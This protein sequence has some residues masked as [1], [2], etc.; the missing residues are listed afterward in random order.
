MP[1]SES[2]D[3]KLHEELGK[4]L[5]ALLTSL[6]GSAALVEIERVLYLASRFLPRLARLSQPALKNLAENL[7]KQGTL[8]FCEG[9]WFVPKASDEQIRKLLAS[10]AYSGLADCIARAIP[11]I[12]NR[13]L[14]DLN[15]LKRDIRNAFFAWDTKLLNASLVSMRDYFPDEYNDGEGFDFLLK[16]QD[17]DSL[18]DLPETLLAV[19]SWQLLPI[20]IRE[21]YDIRK[22]E[23]KLLAVSDSLPLAAIYP[24]IDYEILRGNWNTAATLIK[25]NTNNNARMLRQAWL[26][27]MFGKDERAVNLFLDSLYEV[28]QL[29]GVHDFYFQTVGGLF[30]LF[31]LLRTGTPSALHTAESNAELGIKI[32]TWGPIYELLHKLIQSR[33]TQELCEKLP[34]PKKLD[35]LQD[36]FWILGQYWLNSE[37]TADEQRRL[38]AIAGKAKQSDYQWLFRECEELLLRTLPPGKGIAQ[39]YHEDPVGKLPFLLDCVQI[40]NSW[41]NRLSKFDPFLAGLP[42]Q[43]IRRL[44]WLVSTDETN[45]DLLTVRPMEQHS[46]RS[47][48]WSKG[49]KFTAFRNQNYCRIEQDLDSFMS[50]YQLSPQDKFACTI[51]REA[52]T[53]IEEDPTQQISAWASVFLA[54]AGHPRMLLDGTV[55]RKLHCIT[56]TPYIRLF[57]HENYYEFQLCPQ[58]T[59]NELM[60]LRL[61]HGDVISVFLFDNEFLQLR[62][63]IG[64]ELRLPT[65]AQNEM[66]E[67]LS[68][69]SKR[70]QILSDYPLESLGLDY[71]TADPRPEFRLIPEN[72]GL[73]IELFIKPFGISNGFYKPG[74]G[75]VEMI[76][77]QEVTRH[78]LCRNFASEIAKAEEAIHDCPALLK[79]EAL[80]DWNWSL[81]N[82][83]DCYEFTLQLREILSRCVVHWPE[84]NRFSSTR[85]IGLGNLSLRIQNYKDWFS[86]DGTIQIDENKTVSLRELLHKSNEEKGRFIVLEDGQ[87]VALSEGF[88]HRLDEL[89]RIAEYKNEAFRVHHFLQPVL[90]SLISDIGSCE[91]SQ[92]W[93]EYI[94]KMEQAM[95]LEPEIPESLH[96]TL[97]KYQQE[98]FVWLFRLDALG[99][100]ACLADDMGLGKTIQ[101][102]TL[103]LSKTSEGPSLIIAPTSVCANWQHEFQKFAPSL[104]VVTLGNGDR[105]ETL[106]SLG[107]N[108][109]LISSYGLLQSE[110]EQ[111]GNINWRIAVLD[112]A[113]AI[114]N[115]HAKRSQAAMNIKAKFRLVTTGTPVENNLNELWAVFRFINP[116][117]LGPREL[118][119]RRFGIPIEREDNREAM[120]RLNNLIKPFLLRRRKDQVLK[121]LPPKT[122]IDFTVELSKLEREFYDSLRQ[123][124]LADLEHR[125]DPTGRLRIRVLAGITKLRLATCHPRLAAP[126]STLPGAKLEAFLELLTEILDGGHKTLVF[127][128]FVKFLSIVR[129]SL[130]ERGI[131]YQYLDG[132]L[133][134]KERTAAVKNFQGGNCPVFLISLKAGGLGLNLTQA[135][136]VIHLDSWWNPAVENQA[137]DRAHRL[138]QNKPVTIYHLLTKNTIEDKIQNLHQWKRDLADQIL[139]GNDKLTSFS[140]QDLIK[141]LADEQ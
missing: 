100:G 4:Q 1:V 68:R 83:M 118:F 101:A 71:E 22:F 139:S 122:N 114:K 37:L 3:K 31:S 35:P 134:T 131:E 65:E 120:Q 70:Y 78:R 54:L 14:P 39:R 5:L 41:L 25:K 9:K 47:G 111:F 92:E 88:R 87:V 40:Q 7:C 79:G 66:L 98:G 56:A 29:E 75:P 94:S 113:Q 117:L 16:K 58:P 72:Q 136:Y 17:W 27:S 126:G 104:R 45:P 81:P 115:Y 95:C 64:K 103:I 51:I 36:F 77:H 84:N 19:C 26:S 61:E 44:V 63:L 90:N 49:R 20:A 80:E 109:V 6:S 2:A 11:A 133:S 85:T 141:L 138:G 124:I 125:D 132:S 42:E 10:P 119:Q 15:Y 130:D 53:K 112:E 46:I 74:H 60:V 97:R 18:L 121:E 50:G 8:Q 38:K 57:C 123:G 137:S 67:L 91:L 105:K 34:T 30:F 43:N 28:R 127:S 106:A 110:N 82:A 135:D 52:M 12:G 107:P 69:L 48:K 128:Q 32:P 108:S 24:L 33:R 59:A 62:Q 23:C 96:A 76:T 13:G 140:V 99:A 55:M 93:Q 86:L 89:N 116:G 102:I 73:R 21:L 129:A